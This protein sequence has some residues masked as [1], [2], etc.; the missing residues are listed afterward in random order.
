MSEIKDVLKDKS[1]T[2]YISHEILFLI[3]HYG[4]YKKHSGE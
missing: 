4:P 3:C 2:G 1:D